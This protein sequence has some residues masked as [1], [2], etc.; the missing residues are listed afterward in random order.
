MRARILLLILGTASITTLG[1]VGG[2]AHAAPTSAPSVPHR[3]PAIFDN[4]DRMKVNS[5]DMVVTNHGSLAYDLMTGNA[6]LIYP[7]GTTK[8]AVFA[9]G[10]WIGAKVNGAIR[11]AMG[12]YSQEYVAGPMRNGTFVPDQSAFHNFA[13]DWAHPLSASD[14]ADYMAQGGPR[15]ASGAP[16][17]FGD[18]TFWSVFNDADPD[19]H[20]NAGGM[21]EPLGVEVQQTVF[22]YNRSGPLANAIYVKWKLI[23]KGGNRL[24]STYVSVWSDPDLGGATDD[25][26]GCDTTLSLGFC[27]NATN[28]DQVYGSTPPAVGFVLLRGAVVPRSPGVYDTL[29]MTSFVRYVNGTDPAAQLESYRYM[30]GLTKDGSPMH[31]LGDASYPATQFAVS[32]LDPGSPSTPTNW[33]DS[34]P[35]DRR[36]MLSTGPFTMLP[37]ESQEILF[38]LVI[39][40]GSSRLASLNDLRNRVVAVRAAAPPP[41]PTI[42]S[43]G[44]TLDP[45]TINLASRA[46]WVTAYLEPEGF[47][48]A[49]IDFGSVLLGAAPA[50]P[51]FAVIGDHDADGLPDLMLKFPRAALDPALAPGNVHLDLTGSLVTGERFEGTA[52][53]RVIDPA[54]EALKASLAP[55][56]LNP[57]GTLRFTTARSG[58]ARVRVFDARGRW[59]RTLLDDRALRAGEHEIWID[60]VGGRGEPVASGVYW[61]RIDALDGTATGRFAIV[62]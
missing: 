25:L 21:T 5:L 45:H 16:L 26:V 51:K 52:E 19:L 17:L 9:V 15:D 31:V 14:L 22:A 38:A 55:N 62:K 12:E 24:D 41:S 53:V 42:L 50:N 27:Y 18:A 2:R 47:D 48:P 44:V 35:G 59:V 46:T 7:R 60:G 3:A 57:M 56:P 11:V 1:P 34:N 20:T 4:D 37:G 39:G 10:P 49:A 28:N 30:S 8:T 54:R 33:L 23:N 43:L 32:G 40:Q 36:M 58:P 61:F 13:F 6:G 29:G